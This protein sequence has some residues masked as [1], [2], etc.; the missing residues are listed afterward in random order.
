MNSSENE[1][2][3]KPNEDEVSTNEDPASESPAK[4][5]AKTKKKRSSR[6]EIDC[7][8][9]VEAPYRVDPKKME[10]SEDPETSFDYAAPTATFKEGLRDPQKATMHTGK[11]KLA[12]KEEVEAAEEGFVFVELPKKGVL[13]SRRHHHH[14]HHSHHESTD[15][16]T[17]FNGVIM[18]TQNER[19]AS[20]SLDQSP[21]ESSRHHSDSSHHHSDSSHHSSHGSGKKKRR[22][23]MPLL[24]KIGI[25]TLSVVLGLA[26]FVAGSF[27]VLREIGR[28]SI[29]NYEE[30]TIVAPTEETGKEIITVSDKGQTIV[31]DGETYK[32]NNN[33]ACISIIGTDY[34]LDEN[35]YHAM[36]DAIYLLT[37]DTETGKVSVVGVSRDTI[38]DVDLYS[39]SGSYIDTEKMQLSYA[40]SFENKA[41]SGGANTNEALS[42]LFYGLP[43]DNYYAINMD[44][45][46]TLND[47]IGGV[48]LI[49]SMDFTSPVSGRYIKAGDEVTLYGRDAEYYVRSREDDV[50]ANNS[51]MQRQQ[52]YIRAFLSQMIPAVKK[53]FSLVSKLYNIISINSETNLDLPKMTY[54][55]STAVEKVGSVAEVDFI[56]ID[57]E[58]KE[59]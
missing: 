27:F 30:L 31:F 13:R 21:D 3:N 52:E 50:E 19:P 41:V 14:H 39:S 2:M 38:T 8:V 59:G 51:R 15:A 18:D 22:R 29:H 35:A 57:G 9:P 5:K 10:V 40:Y 11:T 56:S 28:S 6:K 33:V 53:D 17:T 46:L 43:F 48:T 23:R 4:P 16:G 26:I 45:L 49:S 25:I 42:K 55:A 47:A 54:L 36:G 12:S 34:N 32:F 44:A 58:M 7:V 1:Q 37:V 24:A 20:G